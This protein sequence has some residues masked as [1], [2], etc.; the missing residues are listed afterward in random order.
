MPDRER[1]EI[2]RRCGATGFLA[3]N[4]D[5][6]AEPAWCVDCHEHQASSQARAGHP[7]EDRCRQAVDHDGLCTPCA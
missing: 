4:R 2:C 3:R 1:G 6:P 7:C 5:L